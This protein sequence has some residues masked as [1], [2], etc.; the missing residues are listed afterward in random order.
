MLVLVLGV[1]GP[2]SAIGFDFARTSN[3]EG[4]LGT[5][6][7]LV[8]MGGFS[9][10]VLSVLAVGVVLDLEVARGAAPLSLEAFR[11]AFGVMIVPWA[12]AVA[13]VLVSRRRTRRLMVSEGLVVPP[14]RDAIAR[15]R[16]DRASG[17]R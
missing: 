7:G 9:A 2:G 16:R 15:R 14:M 1:A 11:V 17:G 13:G 4:R 10:A 12:V 3:P 6:T 5:A 8:N